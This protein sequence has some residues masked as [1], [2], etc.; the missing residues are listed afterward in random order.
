MSLFNVV[1]TQSAWNENGIDAWENQCNSNRKKHLVKFLYNHEGIGIIT[2]PILGIVLFCF[3]S[4]FGRFY[5][6][7][8]ELTELPRQLQEY[9]LLKRKEI[10][11]IK[12][13]KIQD[14]D[15]NAPDQDNRI[16]S[17]F[18]GN[19]SEIK[20]VASNIY[21]TDISEAVVYYQLQQE[22]F[23]KREHLGTEE[24]NSDV[25]V[26]ITER[27]RDQSNY[28]WDKGFFPETASNIEILKDRGIR[29]IMFIFDHNERWNSCFV[30]E[31][32]AKK[33][34]ASHVLTIHAKCAGIFRTLF[35]PQGSCYVELNGIPK[36]L[37]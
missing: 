15:L 27:V 7:L 12:D 18:Q 35:A 16:S 22:R 10:R 8:E 29:P 9:D 17:L 20:L 3:G 6:P 2:K 31:G 1:P 11:I 28:F 24:L 30:R 26:I 36:E 25:Q 19:H 13:K 14:N 5:S 4:L 23:E 21:P 37:Q 34:N 32:V 33:T